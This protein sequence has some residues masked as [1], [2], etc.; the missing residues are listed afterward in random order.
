MGSMALGQAGQQFA[1]IGTA[2]GAAAAILDLIDR[3]PEI[4]SYSTEGE[5]PRDIKGHIVM[6]D[7]RFSYPTRPEIPILQGITL[8]ALPGETV[9]LVGASGCGKSTITQLLLRYYNPESGKVS[10][11]ER[12]FGGLTHGSSDP[13]RRS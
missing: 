12:S 9:A 13:H 4:D 8:E 11:C 7:V 2:Q 6:K 10:K 3:V 1:V 5:R